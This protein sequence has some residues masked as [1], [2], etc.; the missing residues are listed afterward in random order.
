MAEAVRDDLGVSTGAVSEDAPAHRSRA[1]QT[2]TPSSCGRVP[3]DDA[4][5][6]LYFASPRSVSS[7][8][9]RKYAT[10]WFADLM[11]STTLDERADPELVQELVTS[12]FDLMRPIVD[13]C[14]GVTNNYLGDGILAVFGVP[15][16]YEDDPER[17][18]RAAPEMKTALAEVNEAFWLRVGRTD[19]ADL[20]EFAGQDSLKRT[21]KCKRPQFHVSSARQPVERKYQREANRSGVSCQ[22]PINFLWRE[23]ISHR[24]ARLATQSAPP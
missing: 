11:D 2:T 4:R 12:V 17:A 23:T 3:P 24:F 15:V 14:G 7:A 16:V 22:I 18:V 20:E 5:F 1:D 21:E 10:V 9:E 6:C 8:Q 19:D 13:R